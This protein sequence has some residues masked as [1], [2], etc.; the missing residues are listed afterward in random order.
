MKKILL[1]TSALVALSGAASAEV[2]MSGYARV[3]IENNGT[4][5]VLDHRVQ[6]QA[7]ATVQTD[8]GLSAYVRTRMRV[9]DS[10]VS[11]GFNTPEIKLSY[12]AI[13][14][15]LGNTH[16][17]LTART[18]PYAWGAYGEV[19]YN[20]LFTNTGDWYTS[21]GAAGADRVRV[22]L[23]MGDYVVSVSGDVSGA[24]ATAIGI[25]GSIEGISF[26]LSANDADAYEVVVNGSFAGVDIGLKASNE[27]NAL[28]L[29]TKSGAMGL[30]AIATDND[31]WGVGMNYA[32]GGA[33][34]YGEYY[35]NDFVAVG[36]AF[37][38]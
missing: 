8:A 16:G 28:L 13:T 29:G 7:S 1:A 20:G 22:D 31:L 25:S 33:T 17:A 26:G 10:E 3:G 12:G 9:D 6:L 27:G 24:E 37:S 36:L 38:F 14:V 21:T 5:T 34:A 15:A 2:A 4:D 30:T 18:N 23:A 11:D 19:G 32:L 35:S